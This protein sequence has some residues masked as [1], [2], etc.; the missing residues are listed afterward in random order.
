MQHFRPD[1]FF[2]LS[3]VRGHCPQRDIMDLPIDTAENSRL[4]TVLKN[5][6]FPEKVSVI[7]PCYNEEK[8]VA[9][10]IRECLESHIV[11]EAIV[12]DDGSTDG[13]VEAARAAGARVVRHIKNKGKGAAIMRGAKAAKNDA[14]V[15]IDADLEGFTKDIVEK[16]AYPVINRE[17][18]ICK[19]TYSPLEGRITD[20]TA[21]PLLLHIFSDLDLGQPLSGQFAIRKGLLGVLDVDLDWGVDIAIILSAQKAGERIM[22][23]NIGEIR[24][25]HREH[26]SKVKTAQ[27]VS[28]TILQQAGFLARKHKLVALD[29]DGTLVEGRSID[30]IARE[31]GFM[32]KLARWR[33]DFFAGRMGERRLSA[34]IARELKGASAADFARMAARVKK[35]RFAD[36]TI[37]YLRRMGYKIAVISYAYDLIIHSA[38]KKQAFDFVICPELEVSGG[39]LTGRMKVPKF[40]GGSRLFDKGRALKNHM[41]KAGATKQ[42][43]IA[44]GDSSGDREMFGAAGVSVCFGNAKKSGAQEE[45]C[46]L[47]DLL[48]IAS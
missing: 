25:K 21:K 46:S 47:A 26:A 27:E 18:N 34:S 11:S 43:T 3:G 13:S 32:P 19:S 29:F 36:E 17:C 9:G 22:E 44:A 39:M 24:H 23:V 42:Q 48:I 28:R 10:V 40:R 14:L 4:L 20:F 38:F 15:F 31:L 41:R 33:R 5:L 2:V 16:L 7:I 37:S 12:V 45:I 1:G 6:V 30:I 35:R 8:T